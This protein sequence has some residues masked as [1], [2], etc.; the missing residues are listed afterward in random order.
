SPTPPGTRRCSWPSPHPLG[1]RAR[2]WWAQQLER[3]EQI[4]LV[5]FTQAAPAAG[6]HYRPDRGDQQQERGHLE[7]E[8]EAGEQQLADVGGCSE[9]LRPG[10]VARPL[11]V[12]RLE[13]SAEQRYQE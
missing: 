4:S 8:Q 1:H 3:G 6:E 11:A 12:Y 2:A 9:R 10:T 5:L 7:S 13:A